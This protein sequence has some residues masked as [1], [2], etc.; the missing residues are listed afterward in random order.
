MQAPGGPRQRRL[1][2]RVQCPLLAH[3][4]IQYQENFYAWNA[5]GVGRFVTSMAASGF[6][7]LTLLFLIEMDLLWRLKTCI[8]ALRRRRALVSGS[9]TTVQLPWA[10]TQG[11]PCHLAMARV[12]VHLSIPSLGRSHGPHVTRCS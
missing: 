8:C 9:P 10:H 7:Y 1:G 3:T 4:D 5:P 12:H 11:G 6:A 2:C